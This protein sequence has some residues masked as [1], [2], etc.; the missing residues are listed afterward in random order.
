MEFKAFKSLIENIQRALFIVLGLAF[1]IFNFATLYQNPNESFQHPY[2]HRGM[3]F[4]IFLAGYQMFIFALVIYALI[5]VA[6]IKLSTPNFFK[7]VSTELFSLIM[8]IVLMVIYTG[9]F[10]YYRN[11]FFSNQLAKFIE[12]AKPERYPYF[13]LGPGLFIFFALVI[14]IVITFILMKRKIKEEAEFQKKV[15]AAHERIKQK[16]ESAGIPGD[17]SATETS[18]TNTVKETTSETENT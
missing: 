14:G 18:E 17:S 13:Y 2:S 6:I 9:G 3:D 12:D 16:K 8:A 10:F 7:R 1:T 4:L 11:L 5:I 15:E